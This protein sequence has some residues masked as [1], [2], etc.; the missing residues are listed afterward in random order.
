MNPHHKLR[1]LRKVQRQRFGNRWVQRDTAFRQFLARLKAKTSSGRYSAQV[2]ELWKPVA[3]LMFDMDAAEIERRFAAA[4]PTLDAAA[5]SF[6]GL[7]DACAK[8]GRVLKLALGGPLGAVIP[9]PNWKE[10]AQ[11]AEAERE[12]VLRAIRLVPEPHHKNVGPFVDMPAPGVGTL[13]VDIVMPS[14]LY[15]LKTTPEP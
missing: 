14:G 10:H 4:L 11:A 13:S 12:A 9:P 1:I 5:K 15:E 7:G 3:G 6:Q 2:A 8:A